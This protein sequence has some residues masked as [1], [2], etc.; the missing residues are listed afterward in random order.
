MSEAGFNERD[1]IGRGAEAL[2]ALNMV[3]RAPSQ[4]VV[5]ASARAAAAL[6]GSGVRVCMGTKSAAALLLR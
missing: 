4:C 1:G 2:N 3:R 5:I 6:F